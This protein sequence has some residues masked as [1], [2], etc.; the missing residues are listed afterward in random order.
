MKIWTEAEIALLQKCIA[1]GM[2][3]RQAACCFPKR[4]VDIL[5][6]KAQ[7][8]GLKFAPGAVG[9]N[10]NTDPEPVLQVVTPRSTV[11]LTAFVCGDP[12]PG[13]SA[14]DKKGRA[15]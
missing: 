12:A 8:L 15:A 1:E 10:I 14:L 2:T 6:H 5:R 3:A 13:R 11:S 7:R 4:S 9:I